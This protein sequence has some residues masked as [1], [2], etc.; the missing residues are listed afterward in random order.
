MEALLS[1]LGETI[2][3]VELKVEKEDIKN[4]LG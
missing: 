1:L 2:S 4:A 3:G